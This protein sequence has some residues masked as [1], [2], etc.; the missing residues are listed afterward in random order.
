MGIRKRSGNWH[1]QFQFQGRTYSGST[2]L[3]A[4]E[5]N[6]T[7][8]QKFEQQKQRS[9]EAGAKPVTDM[10]FDRACEKFLSWAFDVEYRQHPSTAARLKTSLASASY[11]FESRRVSSINAGLLEDYKSLRFNVHQV[12]PVTL[13]HDLHAL[14]VF[15]QW[16][17]KYGLCTENPVRE[18]TIPSDAN[19]IREHVLSAEEETKY[20]E[21]AKGNKNL[22]DLARLM[23]LQ[24]FRPEEVMSSRKE[25][26]N[27]EAGTYLVSNGKTRASRRM[28]HLDPES[29]QIL[30][31]RMSTPGPWLFPSDRKPGRHI[32]KLRNAHEIACSEAGVQFV[33]YDLRHTYATRLLTQAGVD[34]GTVAACIGHSNLRSLQRYIHPQEEQKREAMQRYRTLREKS[35]WKSG[36]KG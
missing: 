31:S 3:A 29:V 15:F 20:F 12:K 35:G 4:T 6:K 28:V 30:Q 13:R 22:H 36:E 8:A 24:G 21:A 1:Y 34:V 32:T 19:A 16:A 27:F 7:S 23:L 9:V 11:F 26:F 14:S 2:G 18:V 5:R 25:G 33:L 10:P 17:K